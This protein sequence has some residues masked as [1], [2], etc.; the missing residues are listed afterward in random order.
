M[1]VK[2]HL[3]R[4]QAGLS[5]WLIP[6]ITNAGIHFYCPRP[7]EVWRAYTLHTKEPETLEWLDQ[8]MP[9]SVLWDIGANIG[10][11]SL[12]AAKRGV[13][14]V[15]FEPNVTAYSILVNNVYLNE[16]NDFI[17]P[18]HMALPDSHF[19]D[20]PVPDAIKL[21]VDG[22]ELDI[23]L[24]MPEVLQQVREVLVEMDGNQDEAIEEALNDAGLQMV[25]KRQSAMVANSGKW[26]AFHNA[27]FVR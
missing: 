17:L 19:E 26:S 27:R 3:R 21:D 16:L 8:L 1:D 6:T 13:L 24:S 14:V 18:L 25:W 9:E 4:A 15:A 7:V 10:I 20:V 12:Y 22:P 5:Q 2:M 23:L 11:Y